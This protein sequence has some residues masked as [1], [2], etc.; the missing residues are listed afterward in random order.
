LT[1]ET[2][3]ESHT[4]IDFDAWREEGGGRRRR[5][6]RRRTEGGGSLF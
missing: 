4:G 5:R 1:I 6:R 2:L 3:P